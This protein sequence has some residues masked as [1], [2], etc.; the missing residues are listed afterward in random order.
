MGL[1]GTDTD[2]NQKTSNV[3]AVCQ[4]DSS[5]SLSAKI[6][7]RVTFRN[8]VTAI[9]QLAY[10]IIVPFLLMLKD[11]PVVNVQGDFSIKSSLVESSFAEAKL[12]LSSP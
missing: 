6:K 4:G 10:T 1:P 3:G 9:L 2:K 12:S 8:K 5:C 7:S 11:W